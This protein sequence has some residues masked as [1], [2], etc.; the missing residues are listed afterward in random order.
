VVASIDPGRQGPGQL[1]C[2][3]CHASVGH[4]H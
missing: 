3:G 1:V 4:L 2:T